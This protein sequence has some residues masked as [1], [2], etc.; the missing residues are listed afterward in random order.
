MS[1]REANVVQMTSALFV[2]ADIAY[3]LPQVA[4]PAAMSP[5]SIGVERNRI[6]PTSTIHRLIY[7]T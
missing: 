1:V 4:V 3:T 5:A 6:S 2:R 7:P